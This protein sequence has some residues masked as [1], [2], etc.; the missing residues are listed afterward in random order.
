MLKP[1]L[2]SMRAGVAPGHCGRALLHGLVL[3]P[4]NGKGLRGGH[5]E[6]NPD[7]IRQDTKF[8]IPLE[9]RGRGVL[10]DFEGFHS[11]APWS[12]GHKA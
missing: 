9:G 7:Y 1:M 4:E 2:N 6:V 3:V 8:E 5:A 11:G 12:A 10:V